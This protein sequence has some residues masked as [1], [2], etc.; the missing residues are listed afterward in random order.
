[1]S[2]L[3]S[4]LNTLATAFTASVLDALRVASVEELAVFAVAQ[5]LHGGRWRGDA[6]PSSPSGRLPRRSAEDIAVALERVVELLTKNKA[7][8][9]AEEI[10]KELGMEPNEMPRVLKEGRL[11]KRLYATGQTRS[12]RYTVA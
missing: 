3:R 8:L 11:T 7:G 9:R 12:M 1:M 4:T 6:A 5:P 2:S 10:R